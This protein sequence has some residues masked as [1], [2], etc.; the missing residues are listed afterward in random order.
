VAAEGKLAVV[1]GIEVDHLFGCREPR[2]L[3]HAEV[4]RLVDDYYARGV[5]HVFPIHFGNNGFGGG[6]LETALVRA[7]DQPVISRANPLGTLGVYRMQTESGSG[8]GLRYRSGRRNSLG[9]TRTGRALISAL[10]HRGMIVDI[11]HMSWRARADTFTLCEAADY[12]VVAGHTALLGSTSNARRH[13]AA[14]A[15][16]ELDRVRELGG[17]VAVIL[18]QELPDDGASRRADRRIR[19]ATTEALASAYTYAV[20]HMGDQSPVGIGTDFNGF[21]RLPGPRFDPGSRRRGAGSSRAPRVEYPFTAPTGVSMGRSELGR[22]AFDINVDGVA[23]AGML[24]DLMEELRVV[25][26]TAAD[27]GSLLTSAEG[28]IALWERAVRA[29]SA[30]PQPR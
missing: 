3:S 15:D 22:R 26:L 8:D 28:Y 12:P 10:I 18:D 11:N 14:L 4:D 9:L 25:G 29:S 27:L 19:G 20:S 2:D 23:H 5:R 30:P 17:M 6:S 24:P 16:G 1:L 7:V 21:A 13:E